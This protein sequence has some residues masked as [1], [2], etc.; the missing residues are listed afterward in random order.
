MNPG[1]PP[2]EPVRVFPEN[3]AR[4][5]IFGEAKIGNFNHCFF[6][7]HLNKNILRL[8][9]PV[10]QPFFAVLRS[11][12]RLAI[13]DSDVVCIFKPVQHLDCDSDGFFIGEPPLPF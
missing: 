4:R 10:D 13:G 7:C 12:F 11:S 5:N 9:V 3:P 1:E 8:D 6:P 2:M